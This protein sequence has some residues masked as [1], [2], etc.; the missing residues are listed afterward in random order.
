MDNG[1]FEFKQCVSITKSL[2]KRARNLRE[3][4]ELLETVSE[5]SIAHHTYRYF[6]SAHN[7]EYTNGLAQWVAQSLG[8]KSL[9]EHLSNI[10]PYSFL[11]IDDLRLE[12]LRP[13]DDRLNESPEPRDTMPGEEFYFSEA[14]IL[15]FPAGIRVRN[16][17][18]FL[19]G[20]K[21]VDKSSIYYHFY[22]ARMRLRDEADG[23]STDDFSKWFL[24]SLGRV[25]LVERMKTLDPFMHTLE[26]IRVYILEAVEHEVTRDMEGVFQ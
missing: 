9:S 3:F 4:R 20:I 13:V 23:S 5:E 18:E 16:L 26:G 2:G 19:M 12:L 24:N 14:V 10:D 11:T 21:H 6:L 17:A 1:S 7:L 15:V 25:G 8:E 22:E